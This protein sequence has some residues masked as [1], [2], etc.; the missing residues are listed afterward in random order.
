MKQV[1]VQETVEE[2]L[3]TRPELRN[4]N[5]NILYYEFVKKYYPNESFEYVFLN[6]DMYAL[7]TIESVPR[8]RRHIVET[9]PELA[10][11]EEVE[12]A[13]WNKEVEYHELYSGRRSY[14]DKKR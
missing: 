2:M 7:P 6:I 4:A 12:E 10:G 5:P 9:N 1:K 11:D 3:K 8:A 14:W 13:R